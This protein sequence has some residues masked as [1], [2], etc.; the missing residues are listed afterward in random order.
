MLFGEESVP[1]TYDV[2]GRLGTET[3]G[4][5]LTANVRDTS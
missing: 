3:A 4:C 5:F 1:G 2:H